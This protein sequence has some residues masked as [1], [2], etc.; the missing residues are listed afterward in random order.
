[1][2]SV[3]SRIWIRIAVS[4]SYDNNYYIMGTS[5][6]YN[7][8][9][10]CSKVRSPPPQKKGFSGYNILKHYQSPNYHDNINNS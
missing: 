9:I 5:L 4:T 3:S 6:E 2:L 7:Y 10:P 8:C 1:M